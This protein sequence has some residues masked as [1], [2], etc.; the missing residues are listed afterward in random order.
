[1]ATDLVAYAVY[2]SRTREGRGDPVGEPRY[3]NSP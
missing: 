1:M 2:P 3:R